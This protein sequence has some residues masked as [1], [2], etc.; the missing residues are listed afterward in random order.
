[1]DW[2]FRFEGFPYLRYTPYIMISLLILMSIFM[3]RLFY[4]PTNKVPSIE[5]YRSLPVG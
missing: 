4:T 3:I 1:M 5:L 2:L